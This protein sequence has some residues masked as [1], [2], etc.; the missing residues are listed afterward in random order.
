MCRYSYLLVII[1]FYQGCIEATSDEKYTAFNQK[2]KIQEYTYYMGSDT[3]IVGE[4][5]TKIFFK[6]GSLNID[7]GKVKVQFV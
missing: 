7:K 5:G 1:F 6:S 4:Q 3:V 2:Q